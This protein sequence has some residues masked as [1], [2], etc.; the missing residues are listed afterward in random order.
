MNAARALFRRNNVGLDGNVKTAEIGSYMKAAGLNVSPAEILVAHQ[1]LDP[2]DTG[3]VMFS[4]LET[5][6][7]QQCLVQKRS[8][9]NRLLIKPVVGKGKKPSYDVPGAGHTY[10]AKITRDEVSG[11]DLIFNWKTAQ[12]SKSQDAYVDRV[13]MNRVA[14]KKG[15]VTAK[16]FVHH[17]QTD[18]IY[19]YAKEP[20][21]PQTIIDTTQA[22]GQKPMHSRNK[23]Q[24]SVSELITAKFNHAM[25]DEEGEYPKYSA[26]N[27]GDPR[28]AKPI[29]VSKSAPFS[30][31]LPR[32][33]TKPSTKLRHTKASRLK[34]EKAKQTLAPEEK[35]VFTLKQFRNVSPRVNTYRNAGSN[36]VND[37]GY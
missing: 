30:T 34:H 7:S 20:T 14:V 21:K 25:F 26:K 24:P 33:V 18:R 4:D 6:L 28:P 5:F 37:A 16:D 9:Y 8:Q 10:G 3:S 22:F 13:K 29:A 23:A 12:P 15:C 32:K 36:I 11:K 1:K 19:T 35:K 2:R 31:S 27:A 17:S